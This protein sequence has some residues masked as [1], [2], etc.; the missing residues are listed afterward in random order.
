M[1]VRRPFPK[2]VQFSTALPQQFVTLFSIRF[3]W[4]AFYKYRRPGPIPRAPSSV[5]AV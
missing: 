1:E 2:G 3:T 5:R 4:A